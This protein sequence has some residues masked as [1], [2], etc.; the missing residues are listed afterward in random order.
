MIMFSQERYQTIL[1]LLARHQR[2]TTRELEARVHVSPATL[3]RDLTELEAQ[4]KLIRVHGG[5]MHP[6]AAR[7]ELSFEQRGSRGG[8][9]K[10]A[11]AALAADLVPDGAVVYLD[12]GTT[13]L[14][15]GRRLASRAGLTLVTH[16]IPLVVQA[17]GQAARVV[18]LG[19]ELKAVSQALVGAMACDW[20]D[21]MHFD[22]AFLGAT[23][24]SQ[25]EGAFATALDEAT[26]KAKVLKRS[27]RKVLLADAQKWN[28]PSAFRFAGWEAF[29]DWVCAGKLPRGAAA[30]IRK[31]GVTVHKTKKQ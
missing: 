11:M 18:C 5:V 30:A 2:L 17:S 23:G 7:G 28:V 8:Q 4:G 1:S 13:L 22:I 26:H 20:L 19:G 16:S 29:D 24:L 9:A 6:D 21:Q 10:E 14:P 25:T 3:R 27:E 12:A 15:L 31:L